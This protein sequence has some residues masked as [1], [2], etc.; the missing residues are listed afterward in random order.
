[1]LMVPRRALPAGP[2]SLAAELNG[3]RFWEVSFET[4]S[5][6]QSPDATKAPQ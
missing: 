1:M 2:A 5:Q 3:E 4:D 6:R